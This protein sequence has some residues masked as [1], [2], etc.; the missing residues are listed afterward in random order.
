MTA[1]HAM[2]IALKSSKQIREFN[3]I[4]HSSALRRL[5]TAV[6]LGLGLA[7]F[8]RLVMPEIAGPVLH[9]SS[10]RIETKIP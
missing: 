4:F 8:H 1:V 7:S 9:E 3:M 2:S 5:R 10:G 6:T